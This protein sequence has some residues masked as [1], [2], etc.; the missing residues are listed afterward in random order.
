MLPKMMTPSYCGCMDSRYKSD[1]KSSRR[2]LELDFT[3]CC[4]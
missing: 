1:K 3:D 2:D 4:F